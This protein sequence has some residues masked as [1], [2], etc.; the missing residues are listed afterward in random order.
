VAKD[1]PISELP[2]IAPSA[3]VQL[4]RLGV[5]TAAELLRADYDQVA[6]LLDSFHDADRLLDEARRLVQPDA[7]PAKRA[8][9]G[10][11][12][13]RRVDHK[14]AHTPPP[15]SAPSPFA[16]PRPTENH[17]M[18]PTAQPAAMPDSGRLSDAL[19]M[20]ARGLNLAVNADRAAL[21]RRLAAAATLLHHAS[22]E[23]EVAA[24]LLVEPHEAGSV[25]IEEVSERF[26]AR[27]A[28]ALDECASLRAVPMSP[29]GRLPRLYQDMAARASRTA[30]RVCAA[31]QLA[32][33][34]SESSSDDSVPAA[35]LWYSRLL[36]DA[37]AAGG[38]DELVNQFRASVHA[39]TREAA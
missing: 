30:R 38:D 13:S 12:R 18:Q 36:A 26:G 29:S 4:G 24:A 23:P 3:V 19:A 27:V 21:A 37:L 2:G 32:V 9:R 39:G 17:P 35:S 34:E 8:G 33:L 22:E 14:P 20:A 7:P 15:P 10:A 28:A 16:D 6:V 11:G 1:I 25:S 5:N 31:H